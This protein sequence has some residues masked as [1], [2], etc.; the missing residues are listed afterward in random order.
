MFGAMNEFPRLVDEFTPNYGE[1]RLDAEI[2]VLPD[3]LDG[4]AFGGSPSAIA[5]KLCAV[6]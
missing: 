4:N 1:L 2:I 3:D 6:S 5:R